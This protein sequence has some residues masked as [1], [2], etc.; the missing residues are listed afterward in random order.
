M[1]MAFRW[2][3]PAG[4]DSTPG[5]KLLKGLAG[6]FKQPWFIMVKN[7]VLTMVYGMCM[8]LYSKDVRI[9]K[10]SQ[11]RDVIEKYHMK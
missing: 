4:R 9:L 11:L 3:S 1:A 2:A 8:V 6:W 5:S 7:H 10:T